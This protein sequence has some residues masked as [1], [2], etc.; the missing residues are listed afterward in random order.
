MKRQRELDLR[1]KVVVITGASRGMGKQ[2]A[3]GFARRGANVVI[4]ARTVEP[5]SA[6]P[7]SL[8]ET[9]KEIEALGGAALAVQTDLAKVDD[10]EGLVDAAVERFEIGRHTSELQSP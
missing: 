10:L 5:D 2:A 8:G 6:L 9:L 7:G 1:G 4:A 3:L